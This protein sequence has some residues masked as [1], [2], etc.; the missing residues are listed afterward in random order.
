MRFFYCTDGSNIEGP[1]SPEDLLSF[2]E[3]GLVSGSTLA[4]REGSEEWL[5]VNALKPHK[6]KLTRKRKRASTSSSAVGYEAILGDVGFTLRQR[7]NR[8]LHTLQGL[9]TGF[10]LDGTISD[11]E[12]AELKAWSA[13]NHAVFGKHPF[14]EIIPMINLAVSKKRL[15]EETQKDIVWL[16]QHLSDQNPYYDAVTSDI[17]RLQGI[18]HGALADNHLSNDEIYAIGQWLN[19]H[20]ELQGCFPYDD[21][22]ACL[23]DVYKDGVIDE[24]EREL[25]KSVFGSFAGFSSATTSKRIFDSGKLPPRRMSGV[26]AVAPHIEFGEKVFCFTG[27]T[28]VAPRATIIRIVQSLG[29]L[30]SK[31]VAKD[32]DYLIVGNSGNPAWAYSCYGRKVEAAIKHQSEGSGLQI[33]NEQDFWACVEKVTGKPIA[34]MVHAG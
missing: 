23:N 10:T 6:K 11:G 21:L 19:E 1:I 17:Q 27:A 34:S 24:K 18:L 4:C 33:V 3:Q 12:L 5:F 16:C 25:L 28:A 26:C 30:F 15:D 8:S 14:S 9:L 31:S 22:V 2:V 29:G 32:L 13:E 20:A 7:A